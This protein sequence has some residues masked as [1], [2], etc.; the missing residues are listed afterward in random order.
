M[1]IHLGGDVTILVREVIA[2]V[3]AAA[4]TKAHDRAALFNGHAKVN[5]RLV[6]I[7]PAVCKSYII[8]DNAVYASPISSSTLKRRADVSCSTVG[9]MDV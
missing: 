3:N 5:R 4:V 1:F 6:R 8:T 2:I 7:D 9:D